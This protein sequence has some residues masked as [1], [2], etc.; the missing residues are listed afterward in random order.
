[1]LYTSLI[2]NRKLFQ[3]LGTIGKTLEGF[4]SKILPL[5]EDNTSMYGVMPEGESMNRDDLDGLAHDDLAT[6]AGERGE[7]CMRGRNVMMGYLNNPDKTSEAFTEDEWLRSG[8]VAYLNNDGFTT[9]TG[10][11]KEILITAGGENVAPIAI[12]DAIKSHLPSVSNAMVV[13][14]YIATLHH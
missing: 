4:H 11:I 2:S 8:D 6:D 3:K 5:D 9:I 14:E 13:G 12:E 10:R 1:M 7:I